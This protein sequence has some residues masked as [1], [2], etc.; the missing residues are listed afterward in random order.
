MSMWYIVSK[1]YTCTKLCSTRVFTGIKLQYFRIILWSSPK[2]SVESVLCWFSQ[3]FRCC[4]FLTFIQFVGLRSSEVTGLPWSLQGQWSWRGVFLHGGVE[5]PVTTCFVYTW[6]LNISCKQRQ[7]GQT[8][9]T[10][11]YMFKVILF[12]G[13][14]EMERYIHLQTCLSRELFGSRWLTC[15]SLIW[16]QLQEGPAK[17]LFC[18]RWL[19]LRFFGSFIAVSETFNTKNDAL[20]TWLMWLLVSPVMAMNHYT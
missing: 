4:S 6:Y 10:Y 17:H 2:S 12:E 16:R 8:A 20:Q 3:M 7:R 13:T 15:K 19:H 11:I 5:K 14:E 18:Q 9:N 1:M